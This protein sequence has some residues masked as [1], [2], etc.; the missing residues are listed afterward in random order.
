M[1]IARDRCKIGGGTDPSGGHRTPDPTTGLRSHGERRR[2][3]SDPSRR[4]RRP[5][6]G[7]PGRRLL[8]S[9]GWTAL[10]QQA[11]AG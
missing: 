11:V 5:D 1:R 9:S 2:P 6:R 3:T 4:R 10:C 8:D 7:V